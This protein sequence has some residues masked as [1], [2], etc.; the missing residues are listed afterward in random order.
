MGILI[1]KGL[2]AR[3]LYKLYGVKGLI[4]TFDWYFSRLKPILAAWSHVD[5]EVPVT[6]YRTEAE[7]LDILAELV[8]KPEE[9]Y[10][11]QNDS[12]P[13]PDNDCYCI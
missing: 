12:E 4:I 6:T 11:S 2:T 5:I 7:W 1:F 9:I 10:E 3:H 13:Q 8:P